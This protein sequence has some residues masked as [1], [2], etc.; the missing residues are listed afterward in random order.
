MLIFG[1][2]KKCRKC[3]DTISNQLIKRLTKAVFKAGFPTQNLKNQKKTS[4][5]IRFVVKNQTFLNTS[6]KIY[7][8]PSIPIIF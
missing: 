4:R 8:N 1:N 6:Y 5:K 7:E 3:N 2:G